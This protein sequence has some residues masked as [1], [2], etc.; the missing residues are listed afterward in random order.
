MNPFMLWLLEHHSSADTPIGAFAR[1]YAIVLP[2]TGDGAELRAALRTYMQRT[3]ADDAHIS[4]ETAVFEVAWDMYRPPCSWRECAEP[5][6][7]TSTLCPAHT[8][9]DLL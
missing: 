6:A 9:G 8:L 7:D 3:D 1:K 5:A 4:W 2:A